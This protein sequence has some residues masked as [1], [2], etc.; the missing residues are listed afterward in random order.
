[1]CVIVCMCGIVRNG[2]LFF[3][4]LCCS[5]GYLSVFLLKLAKKPIVLESSH[6]ERPPIFTCNNLNLEDCMFSFLITVIVPKGM[7]IYLYK[8]QFSPCH[9]Q[10]SAFSYRTRHSFFFLFSTVD[11]FAYYIF[12]K[13]K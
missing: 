5:M 13:C 4:F 2:I 1:M 7:L 10:A 12:I 6:L 3:V 8:I 11:S 9:V